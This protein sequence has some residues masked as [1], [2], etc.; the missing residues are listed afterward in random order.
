M[1]IDRI[2]IEFDPAKRDKTLI[3][4]GLDFLRAGEVFDGVHITGPDS[5]TGY[6][7]DRFITVGYLD[8]RLVVMVWTLRGDVRRVISMRK[9]NDREKIFYS[10]YVD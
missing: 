4:R 7:E 10:R 1:Y 9:A 3:E 6:T 8:K 5:R 2:N